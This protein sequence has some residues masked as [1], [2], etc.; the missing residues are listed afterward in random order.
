MSMQL[1]TETVQHL[2]RAQRLEDVTIRV[3]TAARR[4]AGSDGVTFV[5]RDQ[6]QCHYIDEDAIGPLWKGARFPLRQCVTGWVMLNRRP[7][8][9]PDIYADERVPQEAYRPTFVVSMAAVPIRRDDPIGAIGVYWARPHTASA[10][11]LAA[12]Q[13]LADSAATALEH[14]RGRTGTGL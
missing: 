3:R 11:E 2:A 4:L 13:S 6:E 14:V 7:V 5:L 12:L 8:V 10:E 9:I 1:L